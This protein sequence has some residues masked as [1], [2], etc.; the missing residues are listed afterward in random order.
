MNKED[1]VSSIKEQFAE[2]FP[3]CEIRVREV[4][5][6]GE[7]YLGLGVKGAAG[8]E[9][10]LNLDELYEALS[11]DSVEEIV[12]KAATQISKSLDVLPTSVCEMSENIKD[13]TWAKEHLVQCAAGIEKNE[14]FLENIPHRRIC[15][16]GIYYRIVL[17]DSNLAASSVVNNDM[18]KFWEVKERDLMNA[19]K[20][21]DFVFEPLGGILQK[22]DPEFEDESNP[23]YLATN[24]SS[25]FGAG[26][27]GNAF[28]WEKISERFPDG[29]YILPSSIH[30][31][32]VMPLEEGLGKDLS[33][34]VRG[35]NQTQVSPEERLTNHAYTFLPKIAEMNIVA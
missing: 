20:S 2:R 30:E 13:W 24:S 14:K 7:S 29:V 19:C 27:L 35:I 3:D 11:E 6:A 5:K 12:Q 1:F 23:L 26:V 4:E 22:M 8:V 18:L 21:D 31:V 32:L 9:P 10:V 33:A 34:M 28:F 16:I 25:R 17:D 15:D